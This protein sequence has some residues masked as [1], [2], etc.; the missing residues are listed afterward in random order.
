M[1]EHHKD[2]FLKTTNAVFIG[3]HHFYFPTVCLGKFRIHT[4]Q[5]CC[6]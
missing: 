2:N 3:T 6:K 4:E 1:T 5:I